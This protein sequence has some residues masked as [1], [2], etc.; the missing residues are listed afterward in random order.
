MRELVHAFADVMGL[1]NDIVSYQREI[2]YERELSNGV[3]VMGHL[4][5]VD[6][7]EAVNV[8]NDLVTSRLRQF[9]QIIAT[10]LPALF[11]ERELDTNPR[12]HL[13]A[14]VKGLQD[15]LAGDYRWH[16]ETGRYTNIELSIPPAARR[17]FSGPTGVGTAAARIGSLRGGG[18]EGPRE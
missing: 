17:L 12:E 1:H 11:D 13:L 7:Q 2:E 16:Q 8:V 14:Y 9:E 18:G 15:W 10:E 5:N 3:L 6:L 4:L